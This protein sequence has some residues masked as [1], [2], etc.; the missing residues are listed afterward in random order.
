MHPECRSVDYG[1]LLVV[2]WGATLA[3]LVYMF[4]TK[5]SHPDLSAPSASARRWEAWPAA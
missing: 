2:A 4:Y 1:F 5:V 3:T